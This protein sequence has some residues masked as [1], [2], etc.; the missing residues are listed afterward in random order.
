MRKP[1]PPPKRTGLPVYDTPPMPPIGGKVHE[2]LMREVDERIRNEYANA[3]AANFSNIK[4]KEGWRDMPAFMPIS[5]LIDLDATAGDRN[6]AL[7]YIYLRR[8]RE[9]RQ[10]LMQNDIFDN[11]EMD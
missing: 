6:K 10:R 5:E 8:A 4:L 11:L 9:G 7:K 2:Y 3:L 1:P